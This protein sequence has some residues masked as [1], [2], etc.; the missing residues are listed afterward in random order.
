MLLFRRGIMRIFDLHCDTL[1]KANDEKGSVVDSD[2][3]F[4]FKKAERY[5]AYTQVMAVWIPDE[6]R[7]EDAFALVKSCYNLLKKQLQGQSTFKKIDSFFNTESKY[8]IVLSIEG[9][10]AMYGKIEN[11]KEF[12]KMGV[13]LLTLTWNG[14]NEI[15]DGVLCE[16]PKGLTAFGK[17][18]IPELEKNNIIVDVSHASDPLFWDVAELAQKPF[19]A[20]HSNSRIVCGN[21]RN[22]TDNQFRHICKIGGIV[23]LNFY[24]YFVTENGNSSFDDLRNHIEHFLS[25][26]GEN[27]IALGSDFDGAEMPDCIKGV[28]SMSDFYNYLLS[29][30]YSEELVEKLFYYNAK[31]FCEKYD[32]L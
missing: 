8:N 26:G 14:S 25:L 23:G 16:N 12:R 28:E 29:K 24:K 32:N 2:F 4:S 15:G 27:I 22:L 13:R 1:Y 9:G 7:G 5:E 18:V 31:N 20:T 17:Q 3:H 11:V 21:N 10:A 19:V 6:Y 30:N